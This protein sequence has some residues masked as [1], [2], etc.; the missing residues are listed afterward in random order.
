MKSN[1]PKERFLRHSMIIMLVC[2]VVLLGIGIFMLIKGGVS[3]GYIWPRFANPKAVS[4]TWHTPVFAGLLF[5]LVSICFL[6]DSKRTKRTFKEKQAYVF[7]EIKYF[8]QE[9]GFRKRGYNF[10]KKNGEIGYCVNI[11][12]DKCNNNDQVRF[13]LNVGIF[14]DV[15]WLEHF[16]FKHTEV[17][18][19]F[20]KEYDCAIRKR[21]SE[22]LPDHEDKWY[23]INAETDIDELWN[24]LEQDLIGYVV[25]FF[26]NY[27]K[28]SDV[29]PNQVIYKE[30]GKP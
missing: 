12:N 16:D 19:T 23:S 7:D 1:L 15:F 24:D 17:I 8:L 11:Q 3:S 27:N 4:I 25:P 28:V 5:L 18:P 10:F 26:S 21:I 29:A 30:G 2:A 22:L 14:T 9:K 20:P 13:T 6:F